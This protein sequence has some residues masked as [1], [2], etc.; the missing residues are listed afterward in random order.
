MKRTA[1]A[2]GQSLLRI[3]EAAARLG[4]SRATVYRLIDSGEL[5]RVTVRTERTVKTAGRTRIPSAAIDA[6]IERLAKAAK[7]AS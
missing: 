7:E 2:E 6:Y 5:E 4:V 3:P 1:A